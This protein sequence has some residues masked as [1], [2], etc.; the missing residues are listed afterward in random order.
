MISTDMDK[1]IHRERILYIDQTGEYY[2]G[3]E[4]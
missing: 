2:D 3:I 4:R 1:R